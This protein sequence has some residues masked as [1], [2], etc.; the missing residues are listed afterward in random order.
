[1]VTDREHRRRGLVPYLTPLGAWA[2]ALGTAIGWGSLVVTSNTYLLQAGPWGSIIGLLIGAV[3]M[4]VIARNY[5]YM[6]NCFPDSGGAYTYAKAVYGYDHG[7]MTAWFLGLTYMAIFWANATSLP[8]FAKYFLG[9]MFQFGFLYTVF[10]YDVYLGEVLLTIVAIAL[11]ALLLAR[12][13]I[14]TMRVLIAAAVVLAVAIT[15]VFIGS[16]SG[17]FTS[18]ASPHTMEPGYLPD[19]SVLSQ[20]LL[21]ACISPWAFIGFENVSHSAEEF[22]F[23][24][25]KVFRIMV[26]AIVTATLLYLFVLLISVMAYPPEY[27]SWH[28]YIADRGSLAGLAGL[29]PFYVA[30]YYLGDAG[31]TLLMIALLG[32]VITS[33]IGNVLAL[34]RLFLALGKDNI[35]PKR[36]GEVSD[37]HIPVR[38]IVLIAVVSLIVPFLGRTAIGWIVDVTTLGATIVY[39]VVSMTALKVA[40]GRKDRVEKATGVLGVA[41]MIVFGAHIVIP[42]LFPR[43]L[44]NLSRSSSSPPGASSGSSCSASSSATTRSVAS[45]G[46]RSCGSRCSRSSCLSPS[47]GWTKP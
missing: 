18:P 47:C 25:H 22:T 4:I 2:L 39:G 10:G 41:I 5:H 29:P 32:L 12:S 23:P 20:V 30:H 34:S 21:I 38:A 27:G 40:R 6:I 15:A 9:D 43:H 24:R 11:T 16:A 13:R 1:M 37:N 19:E 8:L 14:G 35:L 36:F 26:M 42:S 31:V 45:V 33:L 28:E 44:S 3:V 7:F 17:F 46:R